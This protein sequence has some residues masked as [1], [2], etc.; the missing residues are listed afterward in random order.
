MKKGKYNTAIPILADKDK[1][2]IKVK[3]KLVTHKGHCT[4]AWLI[5]RLGYSDSDLF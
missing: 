2:K 5:C 3:I 1:I 4:I